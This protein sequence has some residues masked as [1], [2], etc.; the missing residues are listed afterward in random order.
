MEK[1]AMRVKINVSGVSEGIR[2]G[3]VERSEIQVNE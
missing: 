3:S 2:G 1:L